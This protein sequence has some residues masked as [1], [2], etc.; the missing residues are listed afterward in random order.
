M[1]PMLFAVPAYSRFRNAK[2]FGDHRIRQS[3]A[4]FNMQH[5]ACLGALVAYMLCGHKKFVRLKA[6]DYLLG[7]KGLD[8]L[9]VDLV[10][11]CQL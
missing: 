11:W 4:M 8:S 9:P 5:W 2:Y 1:D 10:C 6:L 3:G 7:G